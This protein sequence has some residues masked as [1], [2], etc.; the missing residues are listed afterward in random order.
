MRNKRTTKAP[1]TTN[2]RRNAAPGAPN[3][4]IAYTRTSTRDQT[5]GLQAQRDA[6]ERWA[7][8]RGVVV[9]AWFEEHVS[10]GAPLEARPALQEALEALPGH[11]ALVVAKRDRL[12]RDVVNAA[13]IE[14]LA[15]KAGATVTS[16][17]G[18]GE[19]DDPTA[20]LLRTIVDAFSAYE[21]AL[22]RARTKAALQAKRRRGERVGGVPY[23]FRARGGVLTPEPEELRAVEIARTR[24][25]EGA[26]LETIGAELETAGLVT[27]SGRRFNATQVRRMVLRAEDRQAVSI[28]G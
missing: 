11:S 25:A 9:V 7:A 22:I 12:A 15:R 24:R 28:N 4:V 5:T 27:R 1:A 23:G 26:T 6:I 20:M 2:D 16:A 21:R 13:V 19:G 8:A 3:T 17:A 14:G 10:G 18:E